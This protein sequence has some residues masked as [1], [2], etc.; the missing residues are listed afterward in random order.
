[1]K[2]KPHSLIDDDPTPPGPY[3]PEGADDLWFL[4]LSRLVPDFI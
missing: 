1:V 3:D 4:P 2:P